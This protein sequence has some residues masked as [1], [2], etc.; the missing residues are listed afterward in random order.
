MELPA[1][2][3]TYIVFTKYSRF[4]MW[5]VKAQARRNIVTKWHALPPI[6]NKWKIS[7]EPKFLCF[8][9]VDDA[10]DGID[11]ASCQQPSECRFG[12]CVKDLG[13]CQHTQP[14]HADVDHRRKPLRAGDP[15]GFHDDSDQCHAPYQDT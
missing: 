6:T 11:N 7:W 15:A 3:L 13:E 2:F 4:V 14:S 8:Q 9:C 10:T 1:G 5:A 12:Q